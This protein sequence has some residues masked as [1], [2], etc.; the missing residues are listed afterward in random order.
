M[1]APPPTRWWT[2][3]RAA[4]ACSAS[5]SGGSGRKL[6]AHLPNFP[7]N[8]PKRAK[9][10]TRP[11]TVPGTSCPCAA[12]CGPAA[13]AG[14]PGLSLLADFRGFAEASPPC[15]SRGATPGTPDAADATVVARLSAHGLFLTQDGFYGAPQ[16]V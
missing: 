14:R 13:R 1:N 3:W 5:R 4:K 11:T 2:C 16:P 10:A 9:P 6:T 8:G 7:P 15:T 12:P